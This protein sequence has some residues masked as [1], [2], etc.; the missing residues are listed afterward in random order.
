MTHQ[1][2]GQREHRER[3]GIWNKV[4]VVISSYVNAR[5]RVKSIKWQRSS[6]SKLFFFKTLICKI[7]AFCKQLA[8]GTPLGAALRD[9][10][11]TTAA[12]DYQEARTLIVLLTLSAHAREDYS[13]HCVCL[14][15]SVCLSVTLTTS[16]RW[17]AFSIGNLHRHEECNILFG[18][19]FKFSILLRRKT[20]R[21][22]GHYALS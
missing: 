17:Q 16:T 3:A 19:N 12:P 14:C 11:Q 20:R 8:K 1:G 22:L 13:S 18:L 9:P 21:Y 7:A 4:V 6:S 5:A 15:L 2:P 10:P